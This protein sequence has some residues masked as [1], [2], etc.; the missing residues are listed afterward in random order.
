MIPS[1]GKVWALGHKETLPLLDGTPVVV[2]EKVD[3]SQF[4]FLRDASGNILTKSKSVLQPIG[5][6]VT[7][8]MF[9]A[10][11]QHLLEHQDEIPTGIIFRGEVLS[12]P[13]HNSLTYNRVP[14]G[15]IALFDAGPASTPGEFVTPDVLQNLAHEMHV[16][17]VPFLGTYRLHAVN[18]VHE[19]LECESF[20]GGPVI[21]GVVV[22]RYDRYDSFGHA[23]KGKFVSAA[24]KEVHQKDWKDRNPSSGDVIHEIVETYRQPARWEKAVF[25]LRDEGTLDGSPRDIGPLIKAVTEDVL[26]EC[27]GEIQEAL[28]KHFWRK[29]I[30]RGMTSGLPEWY[31]ERLLEEGIEAAA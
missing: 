2:Q 26:A 20:L 16:D 19:L 30:G 31:K 9:A 24:F 8:G 25:R 23:L 17:V 5:D 4:S 11:C 18:A 7:N 21:E 13:K 15:H 12:K 27:K 28:F 6:M 3:G 22:K 10:A 29:G 14:N 1:Y